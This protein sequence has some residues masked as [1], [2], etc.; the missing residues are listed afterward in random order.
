MRKISFHYDVDTD[1]SGYLMYCQIRGEIRPKQEYHQEVYRVGLRVL[2]EQYNNSKG[3][4]KLMEL[5]RSK[6]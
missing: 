3:K 6:R 5:I 2:G 4:E 1:D